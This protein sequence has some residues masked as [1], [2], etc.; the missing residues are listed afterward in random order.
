MYVCIYKLQIE[1]NSGVIF[2]FFRC[3]ED[4]LAKQNTSVYL[5]NKARFG[6]FSGLWDIHC[7]FCAHILVLFTGTFS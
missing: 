3:L 6:C 7:G 4:W 2:I 1:I 5:G